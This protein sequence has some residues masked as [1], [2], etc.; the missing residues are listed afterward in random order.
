[1]FPRGAHGPACALLNGQG[2]AS[3]DT[4]SDSVRL[5]HIDK[6]GVEFSIL[7]TS[8]PDLALGREMDGSPAETRERYAYWVSVSTRWMD[9]DPYGHV[10]NAQYYSF[11]DTAV[12]RMLIDKGVLRGP[13]SG[14]IGLCVES[15]CRFLAPVSF[16]ETIDAGVR[17]GRVGNSSLRYEVG[18]FKAGETQP[19]AVA[20]FVHVFVDSQTRR[21]AP[22][23][24][25]VKASM[26]A[27]MQDA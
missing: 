4:D 25:E 2:K 19:V 9:G 22:L 13:L 3:P 6:C 8:V 26:R 7:Y 21:P 11:V 23:S 27:L 18:L 1:M 24:E 15:G 5:G 10:N 17:I 20:Y 12:T 14:S 16:P